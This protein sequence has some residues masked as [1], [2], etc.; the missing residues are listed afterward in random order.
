MR[1][2]EY[3]TLDSESFGVTNDD[4]SF[5]NFIMLFVGTIVVIS[6]Q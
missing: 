6:I 2:A 1:N 3:T 5:N 4:P